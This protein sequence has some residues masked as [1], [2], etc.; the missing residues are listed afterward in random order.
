MRTLRLL[1]A[2]ALASV[3]LTSC[4]DDAGTATDGPTSTPTSAATSA[5]PD[6]SPSSSPT[7]E[8]TE[9]A[10]EPTEAAGPV[11]SVTIA[12]DDV[13]PNGELLQVA[14]GEPLVVEVTSDRAGELHVHAKPEQY[15]EF[16]AGTTTQE[17]VFETPGVAE[18]EDHDTG[19]VVAQVEV[20]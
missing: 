3:V 6:D 20:R 13:S 8:P 9:T 14:L 17:L 19:D 12:G 7:S 16:E 1:T 4:S 5:A 18:I 2:A 10:P 15:V 11:L